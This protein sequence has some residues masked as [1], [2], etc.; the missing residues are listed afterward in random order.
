MALIE[1]GYPVPGTGGELARAFRRLYRSKGEN[2]S[3]LNVIAWAYSAEMY[4]SH[5]LCGV[6]VSMMRAEQ[7]AV[8]ES[9]GT[10]LLDCS[11]YDLLYEYLAGAADAVGV[12]LHLPDAS[13]FLHETW[14]DRQMILDMLDF[15]R[16]GIG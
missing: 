9:Y 14:V 1:R 6:P 8:R 12:C 10:V 4:L 5:F 13:G 11:D 2:V 7:Y 3:C 15:C 16:D